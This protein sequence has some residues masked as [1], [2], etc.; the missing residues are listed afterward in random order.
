MRF[1][2]RSQLHKSQ[3]RVAFLHP[4]GISSITQ[5][6]KWVSPSV[7]RIWAKK[8]GRGRRKGDATHF[9]INE[10]RPLFA[11]LRPLF[12]SLHP[13]MCSPPVAP[14]LHWLSP[15]FN[16][17]HPT[18]RT[19]KP[20]PQKILHPCRIPPPKFRTNRIQ[21]SFFESTVDSFQDRR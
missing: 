2:C 14:T 3:W 11:S 17:S 13:F 8:R 16:H 10:L 1:H 12:A 20:M 18:H 6:S 21:K 19:L 15:Y 7:R 5:M 4:S 9:Q